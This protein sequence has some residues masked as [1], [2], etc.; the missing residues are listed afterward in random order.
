LAADDDA[1]R[2]LEAE[3]QSPGSETTGKAELVLATH[4]INQDAEFGKLPY[5]VFT[6]LIKNPAIRSRVVKNLYR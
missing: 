6:R 1:E 3:I 4:L 2:N 5:Y